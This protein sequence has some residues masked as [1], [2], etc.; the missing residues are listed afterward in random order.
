MNQN[1]VFIF[2]YIVLALSP[3]IG[4]TLTVFLLYTV[5]V[6][7]DPRENQCARNF[8]EL[9]QHYVLKRMPP[10]NKYSDEIKNPSN[11]NEYTDC[12]VRC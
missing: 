1:F 2:L 12:I 7:T 10:V 11:L 5:K 6:I 4:L 8:K 9:T 3:Y